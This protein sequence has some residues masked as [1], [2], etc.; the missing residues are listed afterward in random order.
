M[1]PFSYTG[2]RILHNEKVREAMEQVRIDAEIA[3]NSQRTVDLSLLSNVLKPIHSR[4]TVFALVERP[5]CF[6]PQLKQTQQ[7]KY[8][9]H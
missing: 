2:L 5:G 4:L 3:H 1:Y 8:K 9:L 7:K 6:T